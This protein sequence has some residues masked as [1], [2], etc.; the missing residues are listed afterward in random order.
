MTAVIPLEIK[1]LAGTGREGP[2][3]WGQ[4][5][6]WDVL[7]WLPEHDT[8][9]TLTA[10]RPVPEG[11][12]KAQAAAALGA[13]VARHEALRT[14]FFT[15]DDCIPRQRVSPEGRIVIPVYDEP[16]DVKK[17]LHDMQGIPFDLATDLPIRAAIALQNGCL[18]I[19]LAVS[20]MSVDSWSFRI[21]EED[22]DNLLAG[23]ELPDRGQQPLDR[24]D[25]EIS[26]IARL[27]EERAL[28][29]WAEHIRETPASM[30]ESLPQPSAPHL[31]WAKIE[32]QA[33]ADAIRVISERTAAAKSLV[34]IA[35]TAHLL[36]R[37]TSEDQAALRMI[38]ATRFTPKTRRF[39]GALTQNALIRLPISTESFDALVRHT[40]KATLTAYQH[41]ECN[42][43]AQEQLIA[44]IAAERNLVSDGYCFFNDISRDGQGRPTSS[45]DA[46]PDP[47]KLRDRLREL[48]A[49]T[50]LSVPEMDQVPKGAT[51]FLF[52]EKLCDWTVLELCADSRFLS[53]HTSIDFLRDL[54]ELIVT[55][56]APNLPV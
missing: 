6:I 50:V 23:V 54:E 5:A 27:R 3:T 19:V 8:S 46:A 13:L 33:L 31:R 45:P 2:L 7:R 16:S 37:Y 32:S 4:L 21:L 9:L 18:V 39:V 28:A 25:Y 36:A 47:A 44:D 48:R 24:L 40:A 49:T 42:P 10:V 15:E 55:A 41:C 43:R 56:A 20:H 52:L 12:T 22:L 51:F 35:A 34:V 53:P 29:Y 14:F 1:F 17:I 11:V 26:D 30:I 38:V